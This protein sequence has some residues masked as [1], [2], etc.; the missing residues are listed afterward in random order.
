LEPSKQLPQWVHDEWTAQ[1]PEELRIPYF[2][3]REAVHRMFWVSM[4]Y[5][6]RD[7]EVFSTT[8]LRLRECVDEL[9][10]ILGRE[11]WRFDAV[12]NTVIRFNI[13]RYLPFWGVRLTGSNAHGLVAEVGHAV[14]W[15][16]IRA[17]LTL[18]YPDW[19]KTNNFNGPIAVEMVRDNFK[20]L[21][22]CIVNFG[23]I[24][25]VER[26]WGMLDQ[27]VAKAYSRFFN[28]DPTRQRGRAIVAAGSPGS[29]GAAARRGG[30][31]N[32]WKPT[33]ATQHVIKLMAQGLSNDAIAER[34]DVKVKTT[35]ANIRQIRKRAID[36]GR[37]PPAKRGQRDAT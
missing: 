26:L 15:P 6:H 32:A 11:S 22:A 1:L 14:Y 7:K 30:G 2:L 10:A 33:A 3:G 29:R 21:S 23:G 16:P 9:K 25:P 27:E 5:H 20:H 17:L 19:Q 28:N 18:E 4:C 36:A 8:L 13:G 12:N 34:E 35:S 31:K 37:L 24:E